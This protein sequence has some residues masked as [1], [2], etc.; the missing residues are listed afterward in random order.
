MCFA[1]IYVLVYDRRT[2]NNHQIKCQYLS[3]SAGV[4]ASLSPDPWYGLSRLI[5]G[6]TTISSLHSVVVGMVVV[7]NVELGVV[8]VVVLAVVDVVLVVVVSIRGK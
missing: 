1:L 5:Q 4:M 3:S 8:A 6:D 2:R 7:D